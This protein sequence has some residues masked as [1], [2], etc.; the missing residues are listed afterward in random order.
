MHKSNMQ[1]SQINTSYTNSGKLR[2]DI[3]TIF[4]LCTI[5]TLLQ[6]CNSL[7]LLQLQL[8]CGLFEN[9]LSIIQDLHHYA[10][11][12]YHLGDA[13]SYPNSHHKYLHYQKKC[14]LLI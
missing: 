5:V 4:I 2:T 7:G 9:G 13:Q 11:L 1:P 14:I 3:L 10:F 12:N 8:I 6:L